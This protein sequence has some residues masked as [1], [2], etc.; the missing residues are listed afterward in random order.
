[1]SCLSK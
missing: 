1:L